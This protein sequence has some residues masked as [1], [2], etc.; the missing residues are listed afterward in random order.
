MNW[1]EIEKIYEDEWKEAFSK[2]H[3]NV[4][5]VRVWYVN[6]FKQKGF[7]TNPDEYECESGFLMNTKDGLIE[8]HQLFEGYLYIKYLPLHCVSDIE[9]L[10]CEMF[11][12]KM[13]EKEQ[14]R[15][16]DEANKKT[17]HPNRNSDLK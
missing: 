17:H 6:K 11:K 10:N 9:K 14:Q 15:M 8:L 2:E 16:Y 1:K 5:Y 4:P 12:S 7:E 13:P 3:P